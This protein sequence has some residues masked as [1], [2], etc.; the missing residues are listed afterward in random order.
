M[1]NSIA[2]K[3][4]T[5][6]QLPI[7]KHQLKEVGKEVTKRIKNLDLENQVATIET[8]QS[9]KKLRTELNKEL[10]DFEDRRKVIKTEINKPYNELEEVYKPEISEKYSSAINLLKDKIA[11]VEDKIKSEKKEAIETYFN[12]LCVAEKIDFITFEKVGIDVK[13]SVTE[14]KYKEQIYDF[15]SKINDDLSLIK[16]TDF[17]AEILTEYKVSL[18]VSGAITSV[19]TRKENEAIETA[20]LKAELIQNRKNYL[21]KLGMQFVEITNSYEFNDDILISTDEIE[22]LS[23]EDFTA[24]YSECEVKIKDIKLKELE[25]EKQNSS[26]AE[27]PV[28]KKEVAAPIS[29]PI[30]EKESEPLKV[31]SFEVTATMTQ[32]RALGAY[33]KSNNITYKNI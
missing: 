27:T 19:K 5:L 18:N 7:I 25:L 20:R 3:E 11:F 24:K 6:V 17:E 1:E 8:L 33:M 26:P 28:I 22:N 14:K 9:F 23:K 4:I 32:L 10:K 13:L 30:V 15:I 2:I 12:E 21:V 29:A 16:S 31:A